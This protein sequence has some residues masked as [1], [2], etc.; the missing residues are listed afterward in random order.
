M[1]KGSLITALFA[2]LS[3]AS[4]AD[5]SALSIPNTPA[6]H[7]LGVW[8]DAFN[9]AD[10]AREESFIKTYASWI[11]LDYA[12]KWRAETGGYDLLDIYSSDQTNVFFRVKAKTNAAEEIGRMRVSATEPLAVT[13]LRTWRIPVGGKVDVVRLEATASAKVIDRV[14]GLLDAFYVF[15][16]TAK[17]MSA[18]LRGHE[19]RGEYLPML[20]GEDLARKLTEDLRA[21]SHDKH[22]E[23]RFSYVV[24][25]AG[26]PTK[27][28]EERARQLAAINCGFE[29]AEHLPP[30]IGYVKFN[31]FADPEICALTASAAMTFLADSDA[32]ILDLRDN[33]GGMGG[34][35]EFIASYLFAERTH[36]NDVFWRPQNATNLQPRVGFVYQWNDRTVVRGGAGMYYGEMLLRPYETMPQ[37]E[38]P[39]FSKRP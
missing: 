18:A 35:S 17:K 16:E 25:P 37:I 9:S 39:D 3:A 19:S 28:P 23:V 32:L 6:G 21:I 7:A 15:P 13:E 26:L 2:V 30:N 22:V 33:N 27:T 34:M 20:Y 36:L 8:L 1:L 29:K 12:V 10:R 24:Q 38:K 4:L 5:V 14:N 31:M 11:N